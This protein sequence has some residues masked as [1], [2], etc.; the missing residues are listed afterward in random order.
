MGRKKQVAAEVAEALAK[1]A[2]HPDATP[3]DWKKRIVEIKKRFQ[4]SISAPQKAVLQEE[5]K[6][7]QLGLRAAEQAAAGKTGFVTHTNLF[8]LTQMVVEHGPEFSSRVHAVDAPHLKRCLAAG[9]IEA[10]GGGKMRLTQTGREAVGDQLIQDIERE[11]RWSAREN[12]FV[13]VEKRGELL[14]SDR[15]E[16]AEKVQRLER[17]LAKLKA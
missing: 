8:A 10:A 2:P 17:A 9:L 16:H 11:S 7:A 15:A 6:A 4:R 3:S 1:G 5:Y 13:P 14:A 12:V